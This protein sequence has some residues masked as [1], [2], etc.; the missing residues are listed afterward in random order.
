MYTCDPGQRFI[1]ALEV[2]S[3]F[4]TDW[5]FLYLKLVRIPLAVV[6][7]WGHAYCSY[8]RVKCKTVRLCNHPDFVGIIPILLENPKEICLKIPTVGIAKSRFW[9]P[10][11]YFLQMNKETKHLT[12]IWVKVKVWTKITEK[13]NPFRSISDCIAF[14][15]GLLRS[16][17]ITSNAFS[18]K[19]SVK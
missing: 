11:S 10:E 12:W 14:G 13:R 18:V 16:A 17:L 3:V 4:W 7:V 9:R 6:G 15:Q 1:Q 8:F 2:R 19:T 5:D